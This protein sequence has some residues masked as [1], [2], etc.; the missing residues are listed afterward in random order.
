MT[1]AK[2]EARRALSNGVRLTLVMAA[3][4]GVSGAVAY[5]FSGAKGLAGVSL[6]AVL[7]LTPGWLV[8]VFQSLYGT[9]APLGV[10]VVGS[11]IRMAFVLAGVLTVQAVR[12]DLATLSFGVWLGVFYVAALATETKLSMPRD[13]GP[14]SEVRP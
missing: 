2:S 10:V 7:C 3:A 4:W 14:S 9:A 13:R 5:G 1:P 6:A 12:P 11:I 8:F